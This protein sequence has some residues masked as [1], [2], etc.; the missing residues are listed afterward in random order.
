MPAAPTLDSLRAAGVTSANALAYGKCTPS[1]AAMLSGLR[2][3]TTG[4]T[5]TPG[6]LDTAY[7]SPFRRLN[8][9]TGGAY[10]NTAV[11]KWHPPSPSDP[12]HPDPHGVEGF[13]GVPG[14]GVTDYGAWA[15]TVD[16]ATDPTHAYVTADLADEAVAGVGRQGS[17]LGCRGSR[18][19]PRR[20]QPPPP[21][22]LGVRDRVR[23]PRR[24]LRLP[25][26]R[27]ARCRPRSTPPALDAAR[28]D[29][30][31]RVVAHTRIPVGGTP[32]YDARTPCAGRYV[33]TAPGGRVRP[34]R[35]V[36]GA[37]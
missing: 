36:A 28:A 24:Y 16:G 4:V 10:A 20:R 9:T 26:D 13:D 34:A 18:T 6:I 30:A 19:P 1:R 8:A 15:R 7:A 14:S 29:A 23:V 32:A 33:P 22:P 37:R 12:D 17:G 2:G 31:A 3:A 35:E 11:G 25:R 27:R 21:Q 5:G